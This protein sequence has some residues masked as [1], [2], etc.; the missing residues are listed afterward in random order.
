VTFDLLA[1][2]PGESNQRWR[3]DPTLNLVTSDQAGPTAGDYVITVCTAN[4]A[5]NTAA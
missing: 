3:W 2:G 4:G 1:V 5:R